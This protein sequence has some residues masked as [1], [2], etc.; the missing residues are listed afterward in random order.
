[1]HDPPNTELIEDPIMQTSHS[2]DNFCSIYN[3]KAAYPDIYVNLSLSAQL[4]WNQ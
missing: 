1:M 2:L 4:L 3:K